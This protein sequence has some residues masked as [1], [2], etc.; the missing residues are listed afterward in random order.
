MVQAQ[1]CTNGKDRVCAACGTDRAYYCNSGKK[2]KVSDGHFSDGGRTFSVRLEGKN[3]VKAGSFEFARLIGT[4]ISIQKVCL[5][6]TKPC[7]TRV[8]DNEWHNGHRAPTQYPSTNNRST[9][10][11]AQHDACVGF[12]TDGWLAVAVGGG[13]FVPSADGATLFL[14]K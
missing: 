2:R 11:W 1:A 14:K 5:L 10:V 12:S 7:R 9:F 6:P 13:G 3:G 4:Q 8:G